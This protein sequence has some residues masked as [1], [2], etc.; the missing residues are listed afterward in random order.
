MANQ[1]MSVSLGL[2]EITS[3]LDA[4]KDW[5]RKPELQLAQADAMEQILRVFD[6]ESMPPEFS[7]YMADQFES[8]LKENATALRRQATEEA[9]RRLQLSTFLKAK[10]IK[11]KREMQ[12]TKEEDP[13]E[14]NSQP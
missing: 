3:L 7:Q 5:E 8:K 13:Y 9:E 11:A 14:L 12:R 10:F 1:E 4:L 2:E 6:P